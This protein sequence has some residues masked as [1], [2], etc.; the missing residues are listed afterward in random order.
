MIIFSKPARP[1]FA[2]L[3]C[4]VAVAICGSAFAQAVPD[5]TQAPRLGPWGFDLTGRD[6]RV[7]PGDDFYRSVAGGWT[8]RMAIPADRTRWGSFDELRELSDARAR[9]VIEKAANDRA[10][11]GEAAQI[12][13]F[14]R[15]F[16]DEAAIERLDVRP[17]ASDLADVRAAR[18]HEQIGTLMGKVPSSVHSAFFTPFIADDQR[19]PDRYAV[20][21]NQSGLGLPD[22]DYYLDARFAPQKAAYQAYIAKQLKA[23][24]WPDAEAKASEIVALETEIARVSWTRA[25]Q[26]DDV[27]MYNAT[28]VADLPKLAPGF[29]WP[30]YLKAANLGGVQR[31]V[32]SEVTAFPKIADIFAKTPVPTLQAWMAFRVVDNASPYLSK[33]FVDAN[34]D[35]RSKTLSGQP[36]QRARWK[37]GV[38]T[39]GANL[40]EAIGKLYVEA[41]FPAQSK[42]QMET[43]VANL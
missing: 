34:F 31:V 41:Y 30:A 37:R 27:K 18:T 38:T 7:Q 32:V 14:Y 8:E 40:G 16:M 13:A 28:P 33:R 9:A 36:E 10:A 1:H 21:L 35:F 2:A 39:V 29:P 4:G 24:E 25:E 17:I 22:R 43:L 3:A 23:I 5:L 12:G 20:Y 6:T 15:S 19:A 26:R 11:R 42:A